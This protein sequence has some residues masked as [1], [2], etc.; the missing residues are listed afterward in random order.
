MDQPDIITERLQLRSFTLDDAADVQRLAGNYNVAKMT[1]NIPHPYEDGMAG[2]WIETHGEI[3]AAGSNIAY[4][5][6]LRNTGELI[7]CISLDDLDGTSGSLGYWI[8]E[9]YWGQGICTEAAIAIIRFAFDDIRLDRIY[10]VRL[11]S[12][13]ASG[14]VMQ[15]VGMIHTGTSQAPGRLGGEMDVETYEILNKRTGS[16]GQ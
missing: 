7:G 4:A 5:I 8:G 9:P 11:V 10:S 16:D 14:R 12:N 13:P 6:T 2:A 3:R 1:L 15:K